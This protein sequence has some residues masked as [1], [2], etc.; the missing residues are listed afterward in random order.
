[1]VI[2]FPSPLPP[3]PTSPRWG[4]EKRGGA[5]SQEPVGRQRSGRRPGGERPPEIR[6]EERDREERGAVRSRGEPAVEEVADEL[7]GGVGEDLARGAGEGGISQGGVT[8]VAL[9]AVL[10]GVVGPE[11]VD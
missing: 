3:H 2:S 11:A 6:P 1:M 4:E 5:L 10:E 7:H 8:D 9:A